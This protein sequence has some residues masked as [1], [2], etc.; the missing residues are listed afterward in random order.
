M[1]TCCK[2]QATEAGLRQA[3]TGATS[4]GG[5]RTAGTFRVLI[6]CMTY[7][8]IL[9]YLFKTHHPKIVHIQKMERDNFCPDLL[10]G[11]FPLEVK[12]Q[13]SQDGPPP[14]AVGEAPR[15]EPW[16]KWG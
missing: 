14:P 7:D 6:I 12:A 13:N 1:H 3:D 16:W 11:F 9:E 4:R 15:A 5:K 10:L 8:Q 2:G